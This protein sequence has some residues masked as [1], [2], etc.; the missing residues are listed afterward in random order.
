ME[1]NDDLDE[2]SLRTET[3]KME[4]PSIGKEQKDNEKKLNRKNPWG[5]RSYA[6]LITQAIEASPEK[7]MTLSQIYDW[8]VRNVPFF[9]DQADSNSSA[10]WKVSNIYT[11]S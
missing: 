5:S 7:R 11:F 4:N 9:N 3:S 1:L 6:D 10:G 2:I 8:M